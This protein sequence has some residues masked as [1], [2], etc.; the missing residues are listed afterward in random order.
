VT[1][2]VKHLERRLWLRR[3]GWHVLIW[4]VSISA[5]RA[6]AFIFRLI[7]RASGLTL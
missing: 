4:I 2:A 7:M 3:L 6:A 5:M 1:D